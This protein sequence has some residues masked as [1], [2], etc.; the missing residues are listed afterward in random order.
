MNKKTPQTL[1]LLFGNI[2]YDGR[3]KRD[4]EIFSKIGNVTLIDTNTTDTSN[5]TIKN[6]LNFSIKIPSFYKSIFEHFYF[7][8]K[9][10]SFSFKT[11]VNIIVAEDY[12]TIFPALII[13]KIKRAP[14]I[15]NSHELIFPE[16]N[17]KMNLREKFW[18]YLEKFS[19][20]YVDLL[21]VANTERAN[22]MKEFYNLDNMPLVVQNIPIINTLENIFDIYSKYPVLNSI[23][24]TNKIILYQGVISLNRGLGRF[25]EALEYLPKDY[26]LLLI[27]NITEKEKFESISK[28]FIEE[29]RILL[30]GKVENKDLSSLTPIA[31]VGII[32]YPFK[33]QN[34]LYC[35]SNKIYE[36]MQANVPV[37]STN[38]LPLKRE[39]ESYNLGLTVSEDQTTLEI[40][41]EIKHLV[42][43]NDIY[44]KGIPSFLNDNSWEKESTNFY[45]KI[46]EYHV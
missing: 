21:I 13:S 12:F 40:A 5:S 36:Y 25:I 6:I 19:I 28:K 27:G 10:I 42:E 37:I 4:L 14:L 8:Y 46:K 3:V 11:E 20:K 39:I 24:S 26:I 17:I 45:E 7:W 44:K 33:G 31:D 2:K 38:Q 43:N 41:N 35:A 32:T 29:K 34:N 30:L 16:K 22:L 9:S 18:F 1:V 15:Y 23:N